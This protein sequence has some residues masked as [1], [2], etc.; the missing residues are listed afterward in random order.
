MKGRLIF[1]GRSMVFL[2]L[3]GGMVYT[4]NRTL[5][6]KYRYSS[7]N[8]LTE[9]FRGFYQMEKN[10]VD[11]LFLGSSQTASGF[12][13]QDLYNEF[14]IR[15]YNLGSNHQSLWA[16]Y[17]WLKE[18][19]KYQSP[20]AVVLD[21]YELFLDQ[22]ENEAHA[23]L[24]FDDMRW[25]AVKKEAVDTVCGFDESQKKTSY[26]FTNIRFHTRWTGLGENDFTWADLAVPPQMKGFWLYRDICND[27]EY[28]P[29]EEEDGGKEEFVPEA[30]EYLN[31]ITE[32]CR[33]YEMELIL[34]KTPTWA[35]TQERHNAVQDYARA[36]GLE[37]YDFNEKGLYEASGFEYALDMNDSSTSGN[38]NAHANPC[39]ARKLTHYLGQLLT[40]RHG[41]TSCQDQQWESTKAFNQGVW[42]DFCLHNETD[43]AA[44]LSML[45]DERYTVFFAVK[46]DGAFFLKEECQEGLLKLGLGSDWE[47]ARQNS[48]YAVIEKGRV[49]VEETAEEKLEKTG[50]FRDGKSLYRITSAGAKAGSDCSIQIHGSEQAKR[51][52][53][54]NIVVYSND[55]KSVVDSVYVEISP[56]GN[57][58]VKR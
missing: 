37:F 57:W 16:S 1:I 22:K 54:L 38:R 48:Y 35:G 7:T 20:Q 40:E 6:P 49:A 9:T 10:T 21:C 23:R 39:G 19:L 3:L 52:N 46:G 33:D 42:K 53:G 28:R 41:F 51:K 11:V 5:T 43:S 18:A 25:G 14:G 56:E 34:V 55:L 31:K 8:P 58:Q 36:R 27:E 4:L 29:F 26:L 32:L 12:N 47:A 24:A 45:K 13:P 30:E 44:Y 2:C 50:S 15:S 17:Y